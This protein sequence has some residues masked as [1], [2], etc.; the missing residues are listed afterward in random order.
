[1]GKLY[2]HENDDALEQAVL[3]TYLSVSLF[4]T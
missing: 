3:Y 2:V 4:K 1:M